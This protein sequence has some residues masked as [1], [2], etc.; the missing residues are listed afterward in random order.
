MPLLCSSDAL[1]LLVTDD[2]F[3]NHTHVVWERL[4]SV[5]TACSNPLVA[6]FAQTLLV[7]ACWSFVLQVKG[8]SAYVNAEFQ[9]LSQKQITVQLWLVHT[10]CGL[11]AALWLGLPSFEWQL[12]GPCFLC[13]KRARS[14]TAMTI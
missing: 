13:S 5:G 9:T 1:F 7:A 11:G 6:S 3:T 2:G 12:S 14:S 8:A 10:G 4:D